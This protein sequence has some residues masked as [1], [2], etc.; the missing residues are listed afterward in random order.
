MRWKSKAFTGLAATVGLAGGVAVP[1]AAAAPAHQA[2]AIAVA[3]RP[4]S[5]QS[6]IDWN[7]EL[8]TL[9]GTPG[10]QP[11]TVHPTRS[12]AML[13]GAEH[14]AVVAATRM[15]R[16]YVISRNAVRARG[17]ARP[18]AAADQ[19]AH[20]VLTAL[21][22]TARGPL[23]GRLD[24]QL[25]AIPDSPA[26]LR[27]VIVGAE[28][29]HAVVDARAGDGSAATPPPF[30]PGTRPGDYQPTP[31][32]FPAP[33]FIGWG[34][35]TPFVL[36]R[37]DQFRPAP[38]PPVSSPE[39]AA[40]LEQVK[41]LGQ[42]TSTSR[43]ADET[44]EAKFWGSA[45]L[46]N[47]WNEVAQTLLADDDASLDRA[48]T[49][50]ANLDLA[51]ADTT[52]A[53]YD[54]KY[55]Y[56]IWRPVTAIRQGNTGYNPDI[57]PD[58]QAPAWN[59]LAVT[60]PDPS[61]PGAHSTLSEAAAT[62]LTQFFGPHQPVTVTSDGLPGVS[63]SFPSIEAVAVEAGLSR[64][65]AGQHT[66]FDHTA[67]RRLGHRVA[68]EVL[69]TLIE[70]TARGRHHG[71][72]GAYVQTNLVSDRPGL[73]RHTDPNLRNAW[74]TSTGPG[75]PIWVSDNATGASTLYDGHGNPVKPAG[76]QQPAV[77]IPAPPSAGP[78]AAGTPD[79]TVFNPTPGGFAVAANGVRASAK[80]LFATE[81]GTI[82]GWSPAVDATRAIIAVD[83]ST[84][85]YAAG[86]HG[87]L[88]KG[89]ALVNTSAGKYLYATNFR[90]G[91]VDVFDSDFAMVG[92]FTDPSLPTGYAPFGI[93]GIGGKL[94]VTF[95]KQ[96]ADKEDDVAGAGHGFVDVFAPDGA[97]LQRFAARGRLD[98][99]WAVTLAP[100]TFGEFAGD[101]LVGNFGDGRINAFDPR[102]GRHLGQLRSEHGP[103]TIPG[104]WG[105]G[106]A[107]DS[108]NADRGALYF[109]A[110]PNDETDGL[111]GEITPQR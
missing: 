109:T 58:P 34:T 37:G 111:F 68:A 100:P 110:G 6:V 25:A 84:A 35:V 48:V 106:L 3:N 66:L 64:I 101:V 33:V 16:P 8:I 49:V 59:Q 30:V 82:A 79:G 62:V 88:Y 51:L 105:L 50:F 98:S 14:D 75:L 4:G 102:T 52:I 104:L 94:Y 18:D 83:R 61:Y 2:A 63:R 103:L 17:N 42:D 27:G 67:G 47:T 39:Y 87:A 54:A 45:P 76:S 56:R 38:H 77:T 97:L 57:A 65:F 26:K 92:S 10:L 71:R 13:Q 72:S 19:A 108:L 36:A 7:R 21:Y 5:G 95:A 24:D 85:T 53:L 28:V 96:D 11:A 15:G 20:D 55:A 74:G 99:P 43:T 86:D 73:A 46:W 22:P 44:L 81:D 23:D 91:T 40:A 1:A 107:D 12:F 93:H 78:D 41:S 9:L 69:A 70:G 90:F 32:N 31:P 29:A 89:L 60:A 80:F